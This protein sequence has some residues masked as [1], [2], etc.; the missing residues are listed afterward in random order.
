MKK[1][2]YSFFSRKKTRLAAKSGHIV[3]ILLKKYKDIYIYIYIYI[4]IYI[5]MLFEI[6][7]LNS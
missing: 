7:I 1:L 5:Y 6:G 3:N 4:S 2:V